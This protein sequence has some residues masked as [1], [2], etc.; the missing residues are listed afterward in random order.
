MLRNLMNGRRVNLRYRLVHAG[1]GSK[2]FTLRGS[3]QALI[4]SLG[5]S[6]KIVGD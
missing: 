6:V 3:K 4:D 2:Q 1:Y 5:P